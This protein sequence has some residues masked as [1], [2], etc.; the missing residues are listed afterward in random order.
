MTTRPWLCTASFW[1]R[2]RG[3]GAGSVM[4][5]WK[6]VTRGLRQAR[7]KSSTRPPRAPTAPPPGRSRAFRILLF[8]ETPPSVP[9]PRE[10]QHGENEEDDE[11]DRCRRNAGIARDYS[12]L[13]TLPSRL[14]AAPEWPTWAA[15]G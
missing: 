2:R 15:R 10:R 14:G 9:V 3:S 11:E 7:T 12:W 4:S 5:V 8:T 1:I 13:T 6:V